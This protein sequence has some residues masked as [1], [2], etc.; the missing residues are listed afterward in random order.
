MTEVDE[1]ELLARFAATD[2]WAPV[3]TAELP[4]ALVDSIEREDWVRAKN[5]LVEVMD[6]LSTDGIYGRALLQ[7]VQRVPIGLDPVMDR[8]RA[9]IAID[10]GHWDDLRRCLQAGAYAANELV[11]FREALLR[12]VNQVQGRPTVSPLEAPFI[13]YEFQ[14]T[15]RWG[16]YKQWSKR[17]PVFD[18]RS[19]FSRPDVPAGRHFRFRMLHHAVLMSAGEAQ[20]G[21]LPTAAALAGEG[22]EMGDDGEPLRDIASDLEVLTLLAMGEAP[23]RSLRLAARSVSARGMSPLGTLEWLLH[24]MPFLTLVKDDWLTPASKLMQRVA[25]RLGSPKAQLV[26]NT[27]VVA[28]QI[29][30]ADQPPRRT[31]LPAVLT[32]ASHADIGL[33]VLPQLLSARLTGRYSA[34]QDTERLARLVGNVWAQI[35]AL[36]WMV[37]LDPSPRVGR[38]LVRLLVSSGWRRPVLVPQAVL[39]DAV[40]GLTSL[41]LRS[42][43]LIELA[44][45]S[46]R[47]TTATEVAR[48]HAVDTGLDS[49]LRLLGVEALSKVGTTHART[50]L[51]E[52]GSTRDELGSTARGLA[53]RAPKLAGLTAREVEV[54]NLAGQGLTNRQIADRLALSHHTVARHLSNS[55]DKLGAAN[56]ADAAVRLGRLGPI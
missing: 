2:P 30:A 55:R 21:R 23:E 48:R 40:L 41:G 1:A 42:Q 45:A 13:A 9:A 18:A 11:M 12:S 7:V 44:L 19:R 47:Q 50:L 33:R 38:Q 43:S 25:G 24:V 56:R 32:N 27:W 14:L 8:H 52:I 53:A 34:F 49:S 4:Q 39:S 20:G 46:G 6:G 15:G 29:A 16:W 10:H 54:L 22:K 51:A 5:E 17:L 36:I 26:A 37:A 28:A 35:S 31:E 3:S